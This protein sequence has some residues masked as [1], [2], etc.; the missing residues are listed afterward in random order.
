MPDSEQTASKAGGA[1]NTTQWV[2]LLHAQVGLTR[3]KN[4][5]SDLQASVNAITDASW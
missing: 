2:T 3:S 5:A 1:V 4:K